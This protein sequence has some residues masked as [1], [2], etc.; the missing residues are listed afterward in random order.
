MVHATLE[1]MIDGGKAGI[2]SKSSRKARWH[3]LCSK[4]HHPERLAA[5]Y[6]E[7]HHCKGC[8]YGRAEGQAGRLLVKLA[9]TDVVF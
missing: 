3:L 1:H 5:S 2:R 9:H 7:G 4:L 8:N 6:S